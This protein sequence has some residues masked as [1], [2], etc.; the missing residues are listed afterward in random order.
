KGSAGVGL[1][2]PL[3]RLTTDPVINTPA[4]ARSV[5]R[6]VA[7]LILG[8]ILGSIALSFTGAPAVAAMTTWA[9]ADPAAPAPAPPATPPPAPMPL[10]QWTFRFSGFFTASLQGSL[11]RRRATTQGQ[12][13]P[14]FHTPPQTL[15]EYGSFV[16]TSTMPGQ[17]VALNFSYGT[18]L[19]TANISLN[20]W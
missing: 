6:L 3:R 5:A 20:T 14:I 7:R 10:G 8:P 11:N 1:N 2:C 13:G 18:P 12:G 19:V 17:W 15:D 4:I 16:G 9:L